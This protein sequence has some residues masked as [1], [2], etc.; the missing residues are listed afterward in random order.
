MDFD[1]ND[2]MVMGIGQLKV[3]ISFDTLGQLI[4]SKHQ[5][6]GDFMLHLPILLDWMG[7]FCTPR[8]LQCAMFDERKRASEQE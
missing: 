7:T 6:K 1:V 4:S 2:K 8:N 3:I 5:I